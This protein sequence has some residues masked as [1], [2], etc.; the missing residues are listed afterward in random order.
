MYWT[1]HTEALL[2]GAPCSSKLGHEGSLAQKLISMSHQM[3]KRN[4]TSKSHSASEGQRSAVKHFGDTQ[5][6]L[7]ALIA[8]LTLVASIDF[9]EAVSKPSHFPQRTHAHHKLRG[10]SAATN[11][12]SPLKLAKVARV[13]DKKLSRG[14]GS[15]EIL[16][17][18]NDSQWS[19]AQLSAARYGL[20][21]TSLPSQDLALFAGGWGIGIVQ[22]HL[23][24]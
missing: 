24:Y 8:I 21:A 12:A 1:S 18:S 13:H 19:T 4:L 2:A 16:N 22:L 23:V 5:C 6:L 14:I 15:P 20:A 11:P 10:L 17:S 3:F 9:A 7:A